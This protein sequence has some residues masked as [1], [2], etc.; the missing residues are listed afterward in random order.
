M[1]FHRGRRDSHPL[2][3]LAGLAAALFVL[4]LALECLGLC[5]RAVGRAVG[6]L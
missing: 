4:G 6:L 2:L 3:R 1:S 5:A